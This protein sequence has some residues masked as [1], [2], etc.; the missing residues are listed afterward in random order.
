MNVLA[1]RLPNLSCVVL[2]ATHASMH[3]EEATGGRRTGGSSMLRR[4]MAKFCGKDSS[5][6]ANLWGNFY[7][8]ST[9]ARLSAPE[10]SLRELITEGTMP[11]RRARRIIR[12]AEDLLVWPTRIQFIEA[13]AALA[14][15]HSKDMGRKVPGTRTTV[16]KILLGITTADR[17]EYLLNNSRFR[18]TLSRSELVLLP[19][20]TTSNEAL[21]AEMNG[22][23]RQVQSMHRSTLQLKLEIMHLAKLLPHQLALHSPTTRQIPSSHVLARRVGKRLWT[24]A[25]WQSWI[26]EQRASGKVRRRDLELAAQKQDEV[27]AVREGLVGGLKRPAGIPCKRTPFTPERKEGV[28]RIGVHMRKPAAKS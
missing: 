11:L 19:S 16:A 25:T 6:P 24:P 2:D 13:L 28:K 22:W 23:F 4:F 21:H 8:G 10:Q 3:Y 15:E 1:Q 5:W 17:I 20:G 18:C 14:R 12:D 9:L 27:Q 7:D 26:M